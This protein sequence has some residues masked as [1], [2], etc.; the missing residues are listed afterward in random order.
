MLETNPLLLYLSPQLLYF[1]HL[2][3]SAGLGFW[4][5]NITVETNRGHI[6]TLFGRQF[7]PNSKNW[8]TQYELYFYNCQD[9]YSRLSIPFQL[10]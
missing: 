10:K 8:A 9:D 4:L 5:M 7:Y 3:T 2:V 1:H 6:L